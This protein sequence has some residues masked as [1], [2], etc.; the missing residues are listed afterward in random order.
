M[1]TRSWSPHLRP[2]GS[3]IYTKMKVEYPRAFCILLELKGALEGGTSQ[4]YI[5]IWV[6]PWSGMLHKSLGFSFGGEGRGDWLASF[7]SRNFILLN[8]DGKTVSLA[9]LTIFIVLS[10]PRSAS[11]PKAFQELKIWLEGPH[12]IFF[13]SWIKKSLTSEISH[14]LKQYPNTAF[15]GL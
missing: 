1:H 8:K 10:L 3:Q 12:F 5:P 9:S 15:L 4:N 13:F 7:F 2:F 6:P 11:S 14:N